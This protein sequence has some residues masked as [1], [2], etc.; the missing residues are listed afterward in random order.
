M[1]VEHLSVVFFVEQ[2]QRLLRQHV[3]EAALKIARSR[4]ELHD[5]LLALLRELAV[6]AL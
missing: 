1:Q 6:A 3:A 5:C 2:F 4:K